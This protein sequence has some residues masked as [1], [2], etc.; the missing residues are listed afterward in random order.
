M[1]EYGY[2]DLFAAVVGD[3]I[4]FN[5]RVGYTYEINKANYVSVLQAIKALFWELF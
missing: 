5:K 2:A 3:R 4:D 1:D